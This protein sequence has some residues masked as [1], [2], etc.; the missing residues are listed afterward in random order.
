MWEMSANDT[1]VG[2]YEHAAERL[3]QRCGTRQEAIHAIVAS[4]SSS[5]NASSNRKLTGCPVERRM[6]KLTLRGSR[7][8]LRCRA[9]NA[10]DGVSV[11]D[12]VQLMRMR[13]EIYLLFI[14]IIPRCEIN[15]TD[16]NIMHSH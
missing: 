3:L 14:L 10:S 5:S 9:S 12:G 16:R 13:T 7:Q 2:L 6:S 8:V 11:W 4:A 15:C 1:L